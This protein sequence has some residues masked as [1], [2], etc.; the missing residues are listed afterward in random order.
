[1]CAVRALSE[2]LALV[3]LTEFRVTRRVTG[4]LIRGNSIEV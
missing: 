1:M 2:R 4:L 3:R